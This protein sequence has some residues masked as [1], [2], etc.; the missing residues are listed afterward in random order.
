[1]HHQYKILL[2]WAGCVALGYKTFPFIIFG[3]KSNFCNS[4]MRNI[5]KIS[6][7]GTFLL[8]FDRLRQS[9]PMWYI[10][11]SNL[12]NLGCLGGL[13]CRWGEVMK[14]K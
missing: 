14:P 9:F 2:H 4:G 12:D 11:V 7:I 6:Y 8:V 1:M 3:T 13:L 10:Y 5:I